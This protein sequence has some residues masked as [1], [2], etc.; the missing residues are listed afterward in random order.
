M[1]GVAEDNI[2]EHLF[3][4][5]G[6]GVGGWGCSTFR[7]RQGVQDNV[8]HGLGVREEG[9]GP[10]LGPAQEEGEDQGDASAA[11]RWAVNL[12]VR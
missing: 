4:F 7:V 5:L 9:E 8:G 10:V 12:L 11:S 3:F 6:G 2:G 1:K